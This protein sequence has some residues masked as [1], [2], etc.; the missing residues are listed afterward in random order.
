MVKMSCA[1]IL[2]FMIILLIM[3]LAIYCSGKNT[4]FGC[5]E[6]ERNA[7]LKLRASFIDPSNRLSSWN[8]KDCCTWQGVACHETTR[9]VMTLDLKNAD[10]RYAFSEYFNGRLSSEELD[11]SLLELKNLSYL[12]LSWNNFQLS[13]IPPFLGSMKQLQYLNLCGANFSGVVPYQLGNLSSLRV[14]DINAWYGNLAIDNLMWVSNFSSLKQLDMSSVNL[15]QTKDLF[16][17][18]RLHSEF[19]W[20]SLLIVLVTFE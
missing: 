4:T 16:Q 1:T 8:T 15:S 6:R 20:R 19:H 12:D 5:I 7:L 17:A 13:P 9:H 18:F 10:Y 3:E 11:S 14:L 2:H